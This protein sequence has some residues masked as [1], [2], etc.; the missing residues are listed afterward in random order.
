MT[1]TTPPR[2][3]RAHGPV[4]PEALIEEARRRT[5]RRRLWYSAAALLA[6]AGS[7]A[8][9]GHGGGAHRPT[10]RG[11]NPASGGQTVVRARIA[12]V[13][14]PGQLTMIGLPSNNGLGP[15]G[16][17]ELSTV[18]NGRIQPFIRCPKPASWCGDVL[19][20]AWARDGT[21]I[22]FS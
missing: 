6:A 21:R 22:A 15:P 7:L 13:A 17:Y 8:V 11:D 18:V 4:D 3:S 5:R 9:F 19:S 12:P 14:R 2:P 20:L 16:W 1:L 10:A